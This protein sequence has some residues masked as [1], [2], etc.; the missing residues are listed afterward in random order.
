MPPCRSPA[1]PERD[2]LMAAEIGEAQSILLPGGGRLGYRE[3]GDPE[4][5]PCVYTPSYMFSNA[6]GVLYDEAAR[7]GVVSVDR[8]GSRRARHVQPGLRPLSPAPRQVHH[9]PGRPPGPHQALG[10]GENAGD[11]HA[12]ATAHHLPDRVDKVLLISGNGPL[13][14]TLLR[15][16]LPISSRLL[17]IMAKHAPGLFRARSVPR[18]DLGD[19]AVARTP[20]GVHPQ[21]PRSPRVQH[22]HAGERLHRVGPVHEGGDARRRSDEGRPPPGRRCV[23]CTR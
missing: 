5:V 18:L 3:F 8:G 17:R 4:G 20:G 9:P 1:V 23:T 16:G 11:S 12:L 14:S 6:L 15:A 2:C 13:R 22:H 19:A 7:E 21:A 10:G